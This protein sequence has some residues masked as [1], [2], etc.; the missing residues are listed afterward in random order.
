[1]III[2]HRG[3]SGYFTEN[4]LAAIQYSSKMNLHAI[5]IDIQ[6]TKDNHPIVI[7]NSTLYE[8]YKIDKFVN[9][10]DWNYIQNITNIIDLKKVIE[11]LGN[12]KQL[13]IEIKG[14]F[15]SVGNQNVMKILNN[16]L[17]NE[18]NNKLKNDIIIC[19]FNE[20][21]C[22]YFIENSKYKVF[23]LTSNIFHNWDKY[24]IYDGISIHLECV[25]KEIIDYFHKHNKKIYVFTVNENIIFKKLEEMNIDAVITDY[26]YILY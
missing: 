16:K 9:E 11:N 19:S 1:M 10:L 4:S 14:K 15:N 2:G 8:L 7:H 3:G 5:E 17:N 22:Q 18:L 21:I 13:V 12:I 23:F 25:S 24:L 6:F 20:E 26:P